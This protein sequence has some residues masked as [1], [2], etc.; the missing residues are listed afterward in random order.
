MSIIRYNLSYIR[1]IMGI[2]KALTIGA[3]ALALNGAQAKPSTLPETTE[4]TKKNIKEVIAHSPV[5]GTKDIHRDEAK[6][7]TTPDKG[8]TLEDDDETKI[9]KTKSTWESYEWITNVTVAKDL[10]SVE[11]TYKNTYK[12]K[13]ENPWVDFIY[14]TPLQNGNA[15]GN[16]TTYAIE[17]MNSLFKEDITNPKKDSIEQK[18]EV[19]KRIEFCLAMQELVVKKCNEENRELLT[20]KEKWKEITKRYTKNDKI[21]FSVNRKLTKKDKGYTPQ[22]EET[23]KFYYVLEGKK[24]EGTD[25]KKYEYKC[26]DKSIYNSNYTPAYPM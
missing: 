19:M 2:K 15:Q 26:I 21:Y 5:Q 3:A 11:F 6:K 1:K 24:Q 25:I 12:I 7:Q 13:Y 18:K 22:K 20:K 14:I 23:G 8:K 4:N 9:E 10:F 17:F 16:D